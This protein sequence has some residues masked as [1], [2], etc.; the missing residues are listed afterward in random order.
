MIGGMERRRRR[1][2]GLLITWDQLTKF[3]QIRYLGL[4]TLL[5][6]TFLIETPTGLA[7][8]VA[9]AFVVSTLLNSSLGEPSGILLGRLAGVALISLSITCWTYRNEKHGEGVLKAILFYN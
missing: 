3:R 5:T 9:P 2:T 1:T 4:K 7:L 6:A 8:L